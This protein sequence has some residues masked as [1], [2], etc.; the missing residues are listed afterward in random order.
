MANKAK[1]CYETQTIL[2]M[3]LF[4]Q[5]LVTEAFLRQKLPLPRVYKDLTRK[6]T[7]LRGRLGS[8]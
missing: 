7:F 3:S 8:S 4:D 2:L 1:F 5:S 6:T